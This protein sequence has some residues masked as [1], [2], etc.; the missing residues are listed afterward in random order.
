MVPVTSFTHTLL[1]HSLKAYQI[2]YGEWYEPPAQPLDACSVT[3]YPPLTLAQAAAAEFA[4]PPET[5]EPNIEAVL[6][7]PPEIVE[8]TPEAVLD[9]P[10]HTPLSKPVAT[11]K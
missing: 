6:D 10:P 5:V 4:Y 8:I 7:S 2:F 9:A 3:L 11:L 1:T